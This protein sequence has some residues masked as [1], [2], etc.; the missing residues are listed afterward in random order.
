MCSLNDTQMYMSGPSGC[1]FLDNFQL[2]IS[3]FDHLKISEVLCAQGSLTLRG[4]V[5]FG[6]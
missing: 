2:W 5:K 6:R 3:N 1:T 4:Q